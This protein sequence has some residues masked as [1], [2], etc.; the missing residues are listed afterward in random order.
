[1]KCAFLTEMKFEGKVPV[2]H[3]NMRVEFASQTN[4]L[5]DAL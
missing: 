2:N 3:P 1:M 5:H 4:F